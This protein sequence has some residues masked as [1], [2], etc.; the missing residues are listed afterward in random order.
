MRPSLVSFPAS[1]SLSVRISELA[2][3]D[4]TRREDLAACRTGARM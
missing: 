2:G 4:A 3:L 1:L